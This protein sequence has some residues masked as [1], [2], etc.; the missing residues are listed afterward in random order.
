MLS[1]KFKQRKEMHPIFLKYWA[2]QLTL[3]SE[4]GGASNL[5]LTLND[6]R[7][8]PIP[9]Q[10]SAVSRALKALREHKGAILAD[11][12]GL[13]KTIEAGII[14]HRHWQQGK[15]K[16]LIILPASLIAQW[17]D[18]LREKFRLPVTVVNSQYLRRKNPPNPFISDKIV[19]CSYHF[20][21][22]KAKYLSGLPWN[23]C[24]IDEAH[25]LRNRHGRMA[26]ALRNAL[27]DVPKL[28]LTATPIQNSQN[29]LYALTEVIDEYFPIRPKK[30]NS[31]PWEPILIRT[32]RKDSGEHFVNRITVTH[33][34]ALNAAEKRLYARMEDFLL[35]DNL[36]CLNEGNR[37]LVKMTLR[38]LL[39]SCPSN[40]AG[41]LERLAQRLQEICTQSALIPDLTSSTEELRE[42][43]K[44][45]LKPKRHKPTPKELEELRLEIK[46][47]RELRRLANQTIS[48]GKSKAL[49]YALREGLRQVQKAGGRKMAIIVTEFLQSQ[50][51]IFDELQA[52]PEFK[53]RVVMIN[54]DNLNP[55]ADAI[56]CTWKEKM[57]PSKSN[58][59]LDRKTAI[60]DHFRRKADI[61]IATDAASEGLNLQFCSL[62]VNY[63]LPWNPQRIGQRIGR[64]HRCEQKNDVVVVNF[65]NA[66][67]Q[68]EQRLLELLTHKLEIFNRVLGSSDSTL[69]EVEDGKKFERWIGE[70]F[71]RCRTSEEINRAFEAIEVASVELDDSMKQTRLFHIADEIEEH[72]QKLWQ[73]CKYV[74]EKWGSFSDKTMT[75]HIPE[76]LEYEQ[77]ELKSGKYSLLPQSKR[78]GYRTLDQQSPIVQAALGCCRKLP[79]KSAILQIPAG[80]VPGTGGFLQVCLL[81]C[82]CHYE[83][84][85][86]I[87]TGY[88]DTCEALSE[89]QCRELLKHGQIVP[90]SPH[91]PRKA[92]EQ[93]TALQIANEH[94]RL[95]EAFRQHIASF[96]ERLSQW[97]S[98]KLTLLKERLTTLK[99][100]SLEFD[101]HWQQ[102]RNEKEALAQKKELT[103]MQ[104][105]RDYAPALET[106]ELF[107][108]QWIVI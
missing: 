25:H 66:D 58:P 90:G 27:R 21:N 59:N 105:R 33:K 62:L 84:E 88:S 45:L 95:Q 81:K 5:A 36:L 68:A 60:L 97:K 85:K 26:T 69:G 102:Y 72:R 79:N 100:D 108:L 94:T 16:I 43:E 23:L 17:I 106:Q 96:E 55:Y 22:N 67:N 82:R 56:Y 91:R 77:T 14:I 46:E 9:Y 24:C 3:R 103:L 38:R 41:T 65:L 2:Q 64:C 104:A 89:E 32:L 49:L 35:R 15:R 48:T 13:G 12:V 63:D 71:L 92:L 98:E 50:R 6:I 74:Y 40:L 78:R 53:G 76:E 11:E 107:T 87:H 86:L 51:H 70:I 1:R 18:E 37:Q 29:D 31:K 34:F 28:L 7:I 52:I 10:I 4:D 39:A 42:M 80:I 75:F 8:N 93:L 30:D 20:A 19:L 61:L 47:L 99:P 73:I 83:Y 54:G 57:R 101:R 44:V